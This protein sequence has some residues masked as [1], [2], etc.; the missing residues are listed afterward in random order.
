MPKPLLQHW[1]EQIGWHVEKGGLEGEVLFDPHAL[2]SGS[3]GLS[4]AAT[5][6]GRAHTLREIWSAEELARCAVLVT[7]SERLSLEQRHA[8]ASV[9]LPARA[10]IKGGGS[11]GSGSL[12]GE[13]SVLCEV[14]WVR[15]VC[16]EG[17]SLGGG[18]LTNAKVLLDSIPAERRWVLSG[19]PAKESSDSDGVAMLGG[20]LAFLRDPRRKAEWA[21]LS[22]R[23]V[24]A[25]A[26]AATAAA[27]AG[28]VGAASSSASSSASPPASDFSG[29][30]ANTLRLA[31]VEAEAEAKAS[32]KAMVAYLS[33]LMVRQLK[34]KIRVPLPIRQTVH[35]EC[36]ASERLAYNSLVSYIHANLVLTSLKGAEHGAGSDVSLL[37]HSN[38]KSARAA[39]E[40]IRLTCNGG[41]KQVASLS[42]E[43]FEEARLWLQERYRAPQRA[44][45]RATRFMQCAQDGTPLPCDS[46]ELPLL[47]LLIMPMCGHL[48][49]PECVGG[50]AGD[51]ELSACPVCA[52]PLPPVRYL[53]CTKC[54]DFSCAHG[55]RRIL[56][57]A[58]PLDGF[59]YLQPGFDLQWAETL[60]ESEARALAEAYSLAA[61]L[62]GGYEKGGGGGRRYAGRH[63][64]AQPSR[65]RRKDCAA[66]L[67]RWRRLG[68]FRPRGEW[69]NGR[70]F[71]RRKRRGKRRRR[72][73]WTVGA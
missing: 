22:R 37:H 40:N 65:H 33:P 39:I 43:Y 14:Q 41:G 11:Q 63:R 18:A 51:V 31:R 29:S 42:H 45:E 30:H 4:S 68:R 48:V 28:D 26:A 54:D 62:R 57:E 25:A 66:H 7:S 61:A 72:Q 52:E 34:A 71:S 1:R 49:C 27:D 53:K 56:H 47:M 21:P 50:T 5:A 9:K 69:L 58:H 67:L 64:C 20:L 10:A 13:P 8:T 73:R 35:L 12:C 38:L 15:L 60:R 55:G 46:C 44:V 2:S 59:A 17:H 3:T 16:D 70:L 23:F 6:A 36:S 19:T 24:R 32:I